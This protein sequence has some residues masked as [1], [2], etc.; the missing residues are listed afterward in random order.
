MDADSFFDTYFKDLN[1][2]ARSRDF[3]SFIGKY[4]ALPDARLVFEHE[5][6]GKDEARRIWTH[7]LPTGKGQKEG[8]GPREVEQVIYKIEDGRVYTWRGL[9]GGNLPRPIYGLQETQFDDRTLIND[10]VIVSAAEK[11][12]MPT[13][14]AAVKSRLGR[15]FIAFA[16]AFNDYFRTGDPD[17]LM[18]WAADDIR[19]V[20]RNDFTGM[21][22]MQ[23]LL[24]IPPMVE[25][26]LADY[27]QDGNVIHANVDFLNWYG[28][29]AKMTLDLTMTDD[30]KFAEVQQGLIMPAVSES[31]G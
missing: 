7:L 4:Y 25:F 20:L 14:E 11:P 16:G 24:R 18:D 22:I 15:I 17:I 12:E 13:D 10:L 23:Q 5:E 27:T 21:A 31:A 26:R 8:E 9:S 28:L 29:D 6:T 1:E 19:M 30:W 3:V 2:V